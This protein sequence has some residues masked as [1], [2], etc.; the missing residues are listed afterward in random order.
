[1]SRD[2]RSLLGR[3][4]VSVGLFRERRGQ[5]LDDVDPT[6]PGMIP[7]LLAHPVGQSGDDSGH[8][9]G[10]GGHGLVDPFIGPGLG[11]RLRL[12]RIANVPAN[13]IVELIGLAASS[14]DGPERRPV[15]AFG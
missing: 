12:V 3:L 2:R 6:L 11:E 13:P 15:L 8:P 1:L 4:A 7:Q 14:F 9:L 10:S 5:L